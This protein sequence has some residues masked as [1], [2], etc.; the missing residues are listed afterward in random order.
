MRNGDIL[1]LHSWGIAIDINAP[2]NQLNQKSKP[3][4]DKSGKTIPAASF[5]RAE[6]KDFIDIMEKN[7]WYSLG[8][9]KNFDYMHFQ[10][11]DPKKPT[12]IYTS[13]TQQ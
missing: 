10:A 8:R 5:S 6:Y 11:W 12:G 13:V 2:E 9:S 3:Y 4:K 7:G 1:S